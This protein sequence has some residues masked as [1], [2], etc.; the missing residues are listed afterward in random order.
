MV[1]HNNNKNNQSKQ[2]HL[3][4]STY[5]CSLTQWSCHAAAHLLPRRRCFICAILSAHFVDWALASCTGA[6]QRETGQQR[7][8]KGNPIE[9]IGSCQHG[10]VCHGPTK[11][12]TL[13]NAKKS[14]SVCNGSWFPN[15][16]SPAVKHSFVS[17]CLLL[18]W[19]MMRVANPSQLAWIASGYTWN[20]G[21]VDSVVGPLLL[22]VE[23]T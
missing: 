6:N 12:L 20:K 3:V 17:R 14:R 18:C 11:W 16:V 10:L 8:G 5:F 9:G 13:H 4:V 23:N 22:N 1:W 2:W 19:N 21:T 7:Y 15:A